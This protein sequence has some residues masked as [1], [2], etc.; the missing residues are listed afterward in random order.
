MPTTAWLAAPSARIGNTGH[1]VPPLTPSNSPCG[2]LRQLHTGPRSVSPEHWLS[3]LSTPSQ[4]LTP[5]ESR[6]CFEGPE[7]AAVHSAGSEVATKPA[8]W[9]G[10]PKSRVS[11]PCIANQIW[12]QSI[13]S[14]AIVK[15]QPFP[16][17]GAGRLLIA[18]IFRCWRQAKALWIEMRPVAGFT[19]VPKS[20]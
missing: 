3:R 16:V 11:I 18:D 17:V 2:P 19:P 9:E 1:R 14:N 10:L 20:Y 12:S 5:L 7:H 13:A 15:H 8:T 6:T 4:Y